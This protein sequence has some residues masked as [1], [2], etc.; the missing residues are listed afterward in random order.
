MIFA[1]FRAMFEDE[2]EQTPYVCTLC[3]DGFDDARTICPVCG[4]FVRARDNVEES[5]GKRG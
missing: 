2:G 4:G 1:R 3:G 5:K